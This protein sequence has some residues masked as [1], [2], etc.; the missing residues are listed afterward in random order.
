MN[1]R[2]LPIFE[3]TRGRIVESIH[4][5]AIAI[6]DSNKKLLYSYGDPQTV[7]FLR[8][9]AKAFQALPFVERGGVETFGLTQREL[10]L[11]CASHEG[12][13]EHARVAGSIQAKVGIAEK[14][15]QCGIHMPGDSTAY[16]ALIARGEKP[17]PNRN[18]CSGKHSGMLA[19]AK[20]RGLPL[21]TYL[22]INHPIQQ[23]ILTGFAEMCEYPREKVELGV[24]GCSAPNFA[25]PLYNAALAFAHL[26]DPQSAAG[27]PHN[28][29]EAC[30]KACNDIT[31][32][33]T[34]FP[35]MIS[36][37]GEF[38]CR[39]MQVG[40]GRIICKRGAEGYQAIGLLPGALGAGSPG[41]GITFKV[42]DGDILFRT[43]NIEP[44]N[45]V[46]PAVTLEILRQIGALNESQLK[47]LAEFGPSLPIKNHR[48]I[49]VGES[50][51]VFQLK[52]NA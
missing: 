13:D 50:R 1:E 21:D 17:T 7:A 33:M 45:R 10:A 47:D 37:P 42:S 48:G 24:D 16:K 6:V 30:A 28:L 18:N 52:A 41:I 5:G 36:G 46:R 40:Q 15:L 49:V 12:S 29:S 25:A 22:D 44:L 39:L 35:E 2:F 26:C 34:S 31:S 43:L 4:Y 51:P 38:D 27:L 20:M 3:L 8:S 19:H 11:I 23:D 14:D 9:S 32:A